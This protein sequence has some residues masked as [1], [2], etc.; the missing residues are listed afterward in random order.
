[1]TRRSSVRPGL[2]LVLAF[3]L[4]ACGGTEASRGGGDAIPGPLPSGVTVAPEQAD[5]PG[6]FDFS[7]TLLDNA[8]LDM[9]ALWAD[10]PVVLFF[11]A[12]GCEQC[13]D[14]LEM[15][16]D[17]VERYGDAVP[18][19]G[20]A[21]AGGDEAA[22]VEAFLEA[23][24][25]VIPVGIDTTDGLRIWDA[26]AAREPPL[27]VLVGPGGHVLRGWPGGASPE[28]LEEAI[29]ALVTLG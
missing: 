19:V 8:P 10:R 22:D 23:H 25:A 28:A 11:F 21:G 3:V 29:S 14:Q 26:Y 5:A 17:V 1:M 27:V 12:S 9:S 4:A 2:L 16:N 18:V 7:L 15:L 13:G 6:A 20:I 24:G